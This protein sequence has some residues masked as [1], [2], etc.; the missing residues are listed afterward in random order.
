MPSSSSTA[1][2]QLPHVLT[3][4]RSGASGQTGP[5]LYSML[6]QNFLMHFKARFASYPMRILPHCLDDA[7]LAVCREHEHGRVKT[8]GAR[9]PRISCVRAS[10]CNASQGQLSGAPRRAESRWVSEPDGARDEYIRQMRLKE[11]IMIYKLRALRD[12]LA[13]SV[14]RPVILLDVDALVLSPDCLNEWLAYPEDLAVQSERSQPGIEPTS[15]EDDR[16]H[17]HD[18]GMYVCV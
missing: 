10:C 1:A 16:S 17:Y 11:A 14:G 4:A 7:I 8:P 15:V 5:D 9:W 6:L 3:F 13:S 18:L 2:S 12:E